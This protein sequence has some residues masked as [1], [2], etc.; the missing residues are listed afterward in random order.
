MEDKLRVLR[1]NID[2]VGNSIF[3]FEAKYV[4]D[5]WNADGFIAEKYEYNIKTGILTVF[6]D[7]EAIYVLF[8]NKY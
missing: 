1:K 6:S 2:A 8:E 5:V 3:E 7:A 4:T